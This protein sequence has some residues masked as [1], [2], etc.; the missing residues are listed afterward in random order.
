VEPF[1]KKDVAQVRLAGEWMLRIK[2]TYTIK[3]HDGS[4]MIPKQLIDNDPSKYEKLDGIAGMIAKATKVF[5]N[6]PYD[7]MTLDDIRI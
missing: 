6:L 2:F 4:D 5:E 1:G 3:D 7:L